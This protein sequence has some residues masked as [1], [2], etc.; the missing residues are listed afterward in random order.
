MHYQICR[1]AGSVNPNTAFK[2]LISLE[3]DRL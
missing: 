2:R 3:A 1:L